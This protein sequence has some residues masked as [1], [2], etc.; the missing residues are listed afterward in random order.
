MPTILEGLDKAADL[1]GKPLGTSGWRKITQ[2]Q[3]NAFAEATGDHQWIH[4][5]PVRAAKESPFKGPIA[6]GYL[7]LSVIPAL[8]PDVLEVKGVKMGVN[9]GANKIRFP[10]PVP[11][12]SEVRLVAEMADV[13]KIEGGVQLTLKATI[14]VKGGQKPALAAEVL[15]RYYA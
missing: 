1:K 14:E 10:S 8:L 13:E 15:Y 5:D 12:G 2:E 3:V 7:T 9:Y 11:V 4:V 6:H